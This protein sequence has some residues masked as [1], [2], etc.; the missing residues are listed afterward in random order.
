VLTEAGTF[1]AMNASGLVNISVL[2]TNDLLV[3]LLAS[4]SD[5]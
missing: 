1:R 5:Y 2:P 4:A 3:A